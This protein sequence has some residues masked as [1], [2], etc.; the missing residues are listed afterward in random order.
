MT[1]VEAAE[2][3]AAAVEV[4]GNDS[5]GVGGASATTVVASAGEG[6]A[7]EQGRCHRRERPLVEGD[8]SAAEARVRVRDSASRDISCRGVTVD[9]AAREEEAPTRDA[10]APPW[11]TQVVASSAEETAAS[12][13]GLV[14]G[15]GSASGKS[16]VGSGAEDASV[17]ASGS[18]IGREI[19]EIDAGIGADTGVE[20]EVETGAEAGAEIVAA[21]GD[22]DAVTWAEEGSRMGARVGGETGMLGGSSSGGEVGVMA[23]DMGMPEKAAREP[24]AT[25]SRAAEAS[26]RSV[27][28][29]SAMRTTRTTS[30]AAASEIRILASARP[31][32]VKGG[33]R[34]A[35][36]RPVGSG[37]G[38]PSRYYVRRCR[39]R[40]QNICVGAA[41]PG[42]TREEHGGL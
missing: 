27:E 17:S 9:A 26:S 16:V 12:V 30:G 13:S 15:G 41:V 1:E 14:E 29:M 22:S 5:V 24:T 11:L 36:Y 19:A 35:W 20:E 7:V 8:I 38:T 25:R 21:N 42:H 37:Y 40:N 6:W 18:D 39:V 23:G 28:S 32:L 10:D 34:W 4:E 2:A 33:T 3:A 31:Y